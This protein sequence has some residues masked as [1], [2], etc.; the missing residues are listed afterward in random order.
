[1]FSR[2]HPY[3]FFVLVNTALVCGTLIFLSLL[4]TVSVSTPE[5]G[6]KVGIIEIDGVIS[7]ALPTIRDLQYF[8]KN[9]L[10]KAILIRINSPGGGVAPSQEIYR[11]I[12]KTKSVKTVIASMGTVA[13]SGGYYIASAANGIVA[14]SGTIT[15]SIGVIMGFTNLESLFQKIGLKTSVVK[16]GKLKD[17][18]S[19]TRP[20][21]PEEESFLNN[22]VSEIHEQFIHDVSK[23]R[24]IPIEDIR[25]IADGRILT[26]DQAKQHNLI[27][28]IGNY[29][30][31]IQWAGRLGGIQGDISTT[32]P[33]KDPLNFIEELIQNEIHTWISK[34]STFK[35]FQSVGYLCPYTD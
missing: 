10:V 24:N 2:R 9:D 6:D 18:G 34:V 27:D 28:R 21:T 7:D 31:A 33:P 25:T 30:D 8:R 5:F 3:L 29:E 16:S 19:P 17:I 12:Q 14:S 11:E 35:Q 20:M 15:G 4:V 26:G 23:G 13:A 1:M 22:F 32:R